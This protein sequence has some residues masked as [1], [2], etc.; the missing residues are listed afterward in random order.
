MSEH[1]CSPFF[2]TWLTLIPK[3]Q[4]EHSFTPMH[5]VAVC[6]L[7][8]FTKH[9]WRDKVEN[10][11][12][13]VNLKQTL[14]RTFSLF[15]PVWCCLHFSLRCCFHTEPWSWPQLPLSTEHHNRQHVQMYA[16][17]VHIVWCEY[18]P[19]C[20][21]GSYWWCFQPLNTGD[22]TSHTQIAYALWRTVT[23]R[24]CE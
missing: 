5:Q 9:Q 17:T 15:C 20:I 21:G 3:S 19:R 16:G 12:I 8:S 18:I 6:T 14:H 7:H 11:Q 13:E 22:V 23:L 10:K 2:W 24:P 4:P 1:C